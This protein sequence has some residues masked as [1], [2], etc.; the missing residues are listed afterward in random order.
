MDTTNVVMYTML[1]PICKTKNK[2]AVKSNDEI[3][4][5]VMCKHNKETLISQDRRIVFDF[6]KDINLDFGSIKLSQKLQ[7]E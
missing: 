6:R 7:E 5:I 3:M 4:K 2:I 1:C